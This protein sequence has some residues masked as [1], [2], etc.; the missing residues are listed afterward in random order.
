MEC[1]SLTEI[2][3]PDNVSTIGNAAFENCSGLTSVVIPNS[4]TSIETNAF[5][6]CTGLTE[7]ILPQNLKTIG[8]DTFRGC[9][10]LL[11]VVS[12]IEDPSYVGFTNG[13]FDENTTINGTLYVPKGTKSL[14]KRYSTHWNINNIVEMDMEY[15]LEITDAELATMFISYPVEIP[16]NDNIKGVYYAKEIVD[17]ELVLEELKGVIPANTAV[18]VSATP[19]IYTFHR[20]A[21]ILAELTDN[22]LVGTD[23]ELD[24]SEIDG[25]VLTLGHGETSGNVGF[26]EFTGVTLQ[27]NKAYIV[28]PASSD[29]KELGI[30]FNGVSTNIK[31]VEN[32]VKSNAVYN[33]LGQKVMANTKLSKGLYIVNGKKVLAR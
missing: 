32:N 2:N 10:N 3:I 16:E 17:G 26:Y 19:S 1:T 31:A 30:E 33:V 7:I 20:S 21:K 5:F 23:S 6:G 18:I 13:I 22:L 11:S 9:D 4:V 27:P 28:L 14:Y 15:D 29:V 12:F 8:Y 24:V 25:K